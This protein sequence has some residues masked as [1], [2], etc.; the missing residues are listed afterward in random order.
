MIVSMR[1]RLFTLACVISMLSACFYSCSE[2]DPQ[3]DPK[4][5]DPQEVPVFT[6][7][8]TDL[9]T[10]SVKMKVTPRSD[11]SLY[12]FDIIEKA[13]FVDYHESDWATYI[14]GFIE[15]QMGSDKTLKEVLTSIINKGEA[16]HPFEGFSP[17]TEYIAVAMGLD[18]QGNI[19]TD[20]ITEE[21]TTEA[22]V[23]ANT[24][25][26]NMTKKEYDNIEFEIIPSNDDFYF[27]TVYTQVYCDQHTDEEIM[28][29]AFVDFSFVM[30]FFKVSGKYAVTR[31]D[32]FTVWNT[33]TGYCIIVFGYESGTSTTKLYKF[34]VRTAK[35]LNDPKDC[36]FNVDVSDLSSTGF[37][38]NVSPSD[39]TVEY[40]WDI[41]PAEQYAIHANDMKKYAEEY[42]AALGIE[43]LDATLS[44][45]DEGNMYSHME[46]GTVYYV[47]A[48]CMD[49][50]GKTQADVYNSAPIKTL[51]TT[52]GNAT[53]KIT[54]NPYFNGDDVYAFNPEKYA[55]CQG[56]AY[57]SVNF[58]QDENTSI[59]YGT[60][61]EEDLSSPAEISDA[62]IISIFE[63]DQKYMFP[64]GKLYL[65]VW[66]T[67][68]TVLAV[69]KDKNGNYGEVVRQ[70][71][72]FTKDGA[73]PISDFKEP[74][75]QNSPKVSF[76]ALTKK[77]DH[78]RPAPQR[79]KDKVI[80]P[81]AR[82][83][84]KGR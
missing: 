6:I 54:M 67:P 20:V 80:A 9:T 32:D 69:A 46:P 51:N 10:Q 74:D 30:D 60:L 14:K 83:A 63:S 77:N 18:D 25:S 22:I 21:F 27:C 71:Y 33:D 16:E 59:W 56:M 81:A 62:A 31:D 24:F 84:A 19:N 68:H 49:E 58:E 47:W 57:V 5:G 36:V 8:L 55:D 40:L 76:K 1:K 78:T 37:T 64:T 2:E 72:T 12:Y 61:S 38:V 7:S 11:D 28:E 15:Y 66:N 45:G 13:T 42:I 70:V 82:R 26:F 53:V 34:P 17:K 79:Y 29:R 65:C 39:K 3:Q 35:S 44:R 73:S 50:F 75:M 52:T 43:Q 23:S 41:I 4:G 48:V